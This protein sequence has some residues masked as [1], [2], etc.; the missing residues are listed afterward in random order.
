MNLFRCLSAAHISTLFLVFVVSACTSTKQESDQ[1]NSK[2]YTSISTS[3][4]VPGGVAQQV[5]VITAVVK[6][7]DYNQRKVTLD[8]K[9]GNLKTIQVG[10]EAVNFD[11]VQVGDLVALEV[12]EE[13]VVFLS[14]Q[15]PSEKS[16]DGGMIAMAAKGEKPL[17]L[18]GGTTDIISTVVA[19][20][21]EAHSVTLRFEDGTERVLGVR[22]DVELNDS[23]VGKTVVMRATAAM[24]IAVEKP[25]SE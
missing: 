14:E 24:A 1:L 7:I 4:G 3:T 18:M 20:D 16:A 22:A 17:V 11:Q 5:T 10:P 9:Q 13:L 12:I 15:A 2:T 6:E 25:E 8:D 19:I 23:Q 21:L